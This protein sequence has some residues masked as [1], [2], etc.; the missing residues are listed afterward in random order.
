MPALIQFEQ[1]ASESEIL[2]LSV[3]TMDIASIVYA[4]LRQRGL[5]I[6]PIDIFIAAAAIEHNYLLVT[7][8]LR[9]F[10]IIQNLDC[11]NWTE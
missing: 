7:A 8:N 3:A 9:H 2:P 6:P 5:L 11:E 1:L 10:S 4:D